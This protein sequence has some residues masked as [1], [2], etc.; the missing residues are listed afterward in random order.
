MKTIK[1]TNVFGEKVNMPLNNYHCNNKLNDLDGT[2][3]IKH[4]KSWFIL[5]AREKLAFDHPATFPPELPMHF[6]EFF[7]KKHQVVLDLFMGIGST[8][9]AAQ[10]LY[11]NA[12]GI[13]LNKEFCDIT[14]SRL[15]KTNDVSKIQLFNADSRHITQLWK[16]QQ[17][18]QVDFVITSP[19][20]FNMLAYS[21]GGVK[22]RH[23][24]L[25]EQG[26]KMTY[27]DNQQDLSN[28]DDYYTFL[29]ELVAIFVELRP[30]MK[31]NAYMVIVVQNIYVKEGYVVPLAFD[32]ACQLGRAFALKP[33]MIWCQ[34]NKPLHIWG[35]PITYMGNYHHHYC[36]VFQ[37]TYD[38]GSE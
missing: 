15:D 14:Q 35:Y 2:A 12:I 36:L 4:L 28:I 29:D 31:K 8:I 5:N 1:G 37:N 10:K 33:E 6:I 20:Y 17:L 19:P 11:R 22:S 13:D 9:I 23:H 21:R 7:T 32:L 18:P 38:A 16:E 30:I 27:G 34:D 3:W 24:K 25:E 26:K